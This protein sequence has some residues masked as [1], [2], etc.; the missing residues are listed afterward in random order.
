MGGSTAYFFVIA[1]ESAWLPM[2]KKLEEILYLSVDASLYST[3][4]YQSL[5][6][7]STVLRCTRVQYRVWYS[8]VQYCTAQW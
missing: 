8:T 6:Q 1:E 3:V 7:Y 4:L 5:V 2:L